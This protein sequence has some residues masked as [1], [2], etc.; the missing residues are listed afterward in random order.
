M[1]GIGI[2]S[3]WRGPEE[4]TWVIKGLELLSYEDRL[5]ERDLL[6]LEKRRLWGDLIAAFQ[7]LKGVYKHERNQLLTQVDSDKTRENGFKLKKGDLGWIS[8]GCSLLRAW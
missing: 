1:L 7:Y 6:G 5:K 3:F 2:G 4:A 8:G